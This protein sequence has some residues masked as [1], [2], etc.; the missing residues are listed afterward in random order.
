[1]YLPNSECE[2]LKS[3][4]VGLLTTHPN[5]DQDVITPTELDATDSDLDEDVDALESDGKLMQYNTCTVTCANA[6]CF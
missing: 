5:L 6:F 1:M 3:V 2:S 4:P